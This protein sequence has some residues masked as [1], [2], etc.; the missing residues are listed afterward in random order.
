MRAQAR[1]I[2][3]RYHPEQPGAL[4]QL[5]LPVI[6]IGP[7][8]LP[9]DTLPP[10]TSKL[11]GASSQ[12]NYYDERGERMVLVGEFNLADLAPYD[13]DGLLPR[14][15]LLSFF[16]GR[17]AIEEGNMEA[18]HWAVAYQPNL[19][20]L[21]PASELDPPGR[22]VRGAAVLGHVP[23]GRASVWG[24]VAAATGRLVRVPAL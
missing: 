8:P 19:K 3:E 15:G 11:G 5:L 24:R 23:G 9:A 21:L 18:G 22:S 1:P 20:A 17:G 12:G 7:T 16:L 10:G 2:F 13:E 4:A 14:S 6:E